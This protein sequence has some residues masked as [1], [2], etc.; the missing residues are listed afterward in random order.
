MTFKNKLFVYATPQVLCYDEP[1]GDDAAAA[2]AAAAVAAAEAAADAEGDGDDGGDDAA[3]AKFTQDQLNKILAED[4]RKEEAKRKAVGETAKQMEARLKQAIAD[5]RN[6]EELRA[7]LEADLED[8]KA[9]QRS[10]A[11]QREH[12]AARAKEEHETQVATLQQAATQWEGLF[13]QS[14]IERSILDAAVKHEAFNND[15]IVN[16]LA[17]KT[18]MKQ[19]KDSAGNLLPDKYEPKTAVSV[20]DPDSG[21]LLTAWKSPEEAVEIMKNNPDEF[22]GLFR[23]AV[24]AGIGGGTAA[25]NQ[26]GPKVDAAKLTAEEFARRFAE[27]PESLGLKSKDF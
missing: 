14:S 8:L 2:A 12:L 9:S 4:R 18:E 15:I 25:S 10:E 24:I 23:N 26:P 16:L 17:S 27:N 7:G 1:S 5:N 20:K 6:S 11:E 3:K 22:G 13:K 19:A 21:E